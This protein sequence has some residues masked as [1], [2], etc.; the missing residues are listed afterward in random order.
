MDNLTIPPIKSF[1]TN[2]TV[3]PKERKE[4]LTS[5]KANFN[6]N[7]KA[8]DLDSIIKKAEEHLPLK[9]CMR[10]NTYVNYESHDPQECAFY[11]H[12]S[13]R[14]NEKKEEKSST[15]DDEEQQS[16]EKN[17][18]W[19]ENHTP[20][21]WKHRAQKSFRT[22][23][24]RRLRQYNTIYE[25]QINHMENK[26]NYTS[27]NFSVYK[28]N[29]NNNSTNWPLTTTSEKYSRITKFLNRNKKRTISIEGNIAS[30]KTSIINIL[31]KMGN[32]DIFTLKEPLEKWKNIHNSNLLQLMYEDPNTWAKSFQS[33]AML[34]MAQNHLS[35]A[36]LK[37]ME[38][39]IYSTRYIFLEAQRINNN[40]DEIN[41][42][43][44]MNWFEFITLNFK[45][46]TDAIIYLRTTPQTA[47]ERMQKRNRPEEKNIKLEYIELLNQLYDD[48]LIGAKFNWPCQILIINANQST[49]LIM[50]DLNEKIKL[51]K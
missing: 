11:H 41:W 4:S 39:S 18:F 22:N 44:L 31:E 35:P 32:P 12:E 38:R 9:P 28:W 47:Y 14:Q 30:G 24:K 26:P 13:M 48:W 40:I 46:K 45:M 50:K 19:R 37:I 7:F 43:I 23:D 10:C 21:I 8:F 33:Y 20:E 42:Q 27:P 6:L 36:L 5:R 2:D 25:Q 34:T 49:E 29:I 51:I 16:N 17:Y 3:E 15:D 1:F